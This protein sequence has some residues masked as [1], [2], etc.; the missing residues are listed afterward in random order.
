MTASHIPAQLPDH[1]DFSWEDLS[2]EELQE[3]NDWIDFQNADLI[4]EM[5]AYY[6]R[7]PEL[8]GE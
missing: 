8:T 3:Y 1:I 4:E 7:H 5:D 6:I 2:P